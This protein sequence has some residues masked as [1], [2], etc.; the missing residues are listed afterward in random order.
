MP[1]THRV[2]F[3]YPPGFVD[4]VVWINPAKV[5]AVEQV[6]KGGKVDPHHTMILTNRMRY[7]VKSPSQDVIR[8]L[9]DLD[10]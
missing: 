9:T 3:T 8:E 10:D 4:Q 7:V 6:V 2:L 1:F 5:H